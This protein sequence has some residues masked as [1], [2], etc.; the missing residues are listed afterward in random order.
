M[1][2]L[3]ATRRHAQ[4]PSGGSEALALI[5]VPLDD[6]VQG[7][8]L[9]AERLTDDLGELE[10]APAALGPAT[11][12]WF[13]HYAA[14]PKPTTL[15]RVDRGDL[16]RDTKAALGEALGD[17]ARVTCW[18]PEAEDDDSRPVGDDPASQTKTLAP[19]VGEQR[20]PWRHGSLGRRDWQLRQRNVLRVGGPGGGVVMHL[21]FDR[22]VDV[23]YLALRD[24]KAARTLEVS[25]TINADV[26]EHGELL[27]IEFLD[28][29]E[30]VPFLR[31]EA[32]FTALPSAMRAAVEE[33]TGR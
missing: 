25:G 15:V 29:G 5:D 17:R 7:L 19:V 22:E 3:S 6:L 23:L 16:D 21:T 10:I 2:T 14:D 32:G 4:W 1:A 24:G 33:A 28:P 27:G 8:R 12:V 20:G 18:N 30:F 31:H 11:Q 13:Y 26:D 9:V